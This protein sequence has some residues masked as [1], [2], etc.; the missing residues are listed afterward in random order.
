[1]PGLAFRATTPWDDP[2]VYRKTSPISYVKTANTPTLIQHGENDK[3]VPIP[4]AYELYQALQDRGG[5]ESRDT[6]KAFAD[7]SG[8]VAEHLSGG[9]VER[10]KRP[11]RLDQLSVDEHAPIGVPLRCA[12]SSARPVTRDRRR[13]RHSPSSDVMETSFSSSANLTFA[14]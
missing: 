3:R 1:V 4:N 7:Y 14:P 8:Y 10:G 5:W 9:G 12:R 13:F 11:W 2:E 6:A